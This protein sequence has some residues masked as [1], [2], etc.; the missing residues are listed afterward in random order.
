MSQKEHED[1]AV[2]EYAEKLEE[3]PAEPDQLQLT[4]QEA[5]DR[6][7]RTINIV[8]HELDNRLTAVEAQVNALEDPMSDVLEAIEEIKEMMKEAST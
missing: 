5:F 8:M 2:E 6:F 4:P 3:R 7:V 1:K